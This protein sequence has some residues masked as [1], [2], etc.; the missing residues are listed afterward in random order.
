MGRPKV[1]AECVCVCMCMR[2]VGKLEVCL[3]GWSGVWE[4]DALPTMVCPLTKMGGKHSADRWWW[5]ERM[6]LS[7]VASLFA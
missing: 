4:G 3:F 1:A 6:L 5:L 7:T 2:G